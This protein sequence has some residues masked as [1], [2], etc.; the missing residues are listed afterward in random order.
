[1]PQHFR[2]DRLFIGFNIHRSGIHQMKKKKNV[3]WLNNYY[4][5]L[6]PYFPKHRKYV[7]ALDYNIPR[8]RA[9]KSYYGDN[10]LELIKIKDKYDPTN[11]FKFEQSIP[12]VDDFNQYEK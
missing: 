4:Q 7:N 9:L 1:M 8:L 2:L 6:R 3:T 10:L 12:A 11:F 5:A